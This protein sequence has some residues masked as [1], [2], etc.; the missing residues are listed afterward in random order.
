MEHSLYSGYDLW[1]LAADAII[2][3]ESILI[4][5]T[6]FGDGSNEKRCKA[7]MQPALYP[8]FGITLLKY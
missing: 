5:H 8:V 4:G 7:R 6:Q 2:P 3:E 1:E